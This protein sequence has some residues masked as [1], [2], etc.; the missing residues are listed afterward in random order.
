LYFFSMKLIFIFFF[1]LLW[2]LLLKLYI[3]IIDSSVPCFFDSCQCLKCQGRTQKRK[4]RKKR[5]MTDIEQRKIRRSER[6]INKRRKNRKLEEE[7]K[8][9][10]DIYT[11]H[12]LSPVAHETLLDFLAR[13]IS[14]RIKVKTLRFTIDVESIGFAK[15]K[16]NLRT[17]K[18]KSLTSEQKL[19]VFFFNFVFR[20]KHRERLRE[21]T[22]EKRREKCIFGW[23]LTFYSFDDSA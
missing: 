2:L 10:A 18:L 3:M 12:R 8:I 11:W 22:L 1:S 16:V 21:K 19:P 13:F 4:S 7:K 14:N 6:R 9:I 17:I 20:S 15:R 5:G 23:W